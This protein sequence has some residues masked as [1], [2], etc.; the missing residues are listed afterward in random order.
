ME[1]FQVETITIVILGLVV[2]LHIGFLILEMFLWPTP[3]V[4]ERLPALKPEEMTKKLA[5][6]MGLYN[7][8]IAAGLVWSLLASEG[9]FSIKLFFLSCAI[10]AG[11]FG[12]LTVKRS[13]FF[14]QAVPAII[15][16]VLVWL[17]SYPITLP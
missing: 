14:F 10:V 2:A 6:N 17:K 15:A 7:G 3:L 4:Q 5:A 12:G 1:I 11:I 13:I 8:F 16:L 9:S